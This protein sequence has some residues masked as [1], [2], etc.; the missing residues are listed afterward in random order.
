MQTTSRSFPQESLKREPVE[1]RCHRRGRIVPHF[2]TK[3]AILSVSCI[4]YVGQEVSVSG[5]GT[6]HYRAS[7]E[8]R[9][10]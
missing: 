2:R 3:T 7:G 1:R 9:N 5:R 4:G 8:H 6:N 10:A